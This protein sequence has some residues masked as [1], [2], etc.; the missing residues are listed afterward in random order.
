MNP[1]AFG[2]KKTGEFLS[3][4]YAALHL[5]PSGGPKLIYP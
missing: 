4:D 1:I 5:P 2:E 3:A